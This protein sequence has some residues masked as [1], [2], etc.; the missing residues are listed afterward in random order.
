MSDERIQAGE[1]SRE[2]RRFFRIDDS[3]RISLEPVDAEE[4]TERFERLERQ[5]PGSFSLMTSL[6]AETQQAA[7]ALRRIE[8]RSPDVAQCLKTIDRK[9]ELLARALLYEE[10]D[11]ARRPIRPVNLSAGGVAIHTQEA[12]RPGLLVQI[13]MLLMPSFTGVVTF[14]KVVECRAEPSPDGEFSHLLRIDFSHIREQDQ[15]AIIRHVLMK[16]AEWLRHRRKM[17]EQEG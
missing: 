14:G 2:R 12:Y 1:S 4:V 16:Q 13:K 5:L 9:I 6:T 11:I 17:Q 15:D 3:V 7:A 10:A 8:G